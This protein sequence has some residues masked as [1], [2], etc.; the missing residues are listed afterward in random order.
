M[1]RFTKTQIMNELKIN[2]NNFKQD[3][4]G[5]TYHD[6]IE[7][8]IALEILSKK[9]KFVDYYILDDEFGLGYHIYASNE[10]EYD[11]WE[12]ENK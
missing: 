9:Y 12:E 2:T 5:F 11:A 7:F 3:V 1:T 4:K 10:I 6:E 8:E